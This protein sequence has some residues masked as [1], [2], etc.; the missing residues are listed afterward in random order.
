M[1]AT[2]IT[3][4]LMLTREEISKVKHEMGK[5]PKLKYDIKKNYNFQLLFTK[6]LLKLNSQL[7]SSPSI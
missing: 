6:Q 4:T 5:Y 2:Y 7:N 3:G 1:R